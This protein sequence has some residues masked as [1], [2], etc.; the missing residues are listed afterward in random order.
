MSRNNEVT[1]RWSRS[2]MLSFINGAGLS[3]LG[4]QLSNP[5]PMLYIIL[6][7]F[8]MSLCTFW[9]ILNWKTQLWIDYWQS[10]LASMEPPPTEL[11]VFRVFTGKEWEKVNKWPTFHWLLNFLP[12]TFFVLWLTIIVTFSFIEKKEP[13]K[14]TPTTIF[15]QFNT[16]KGGV[17]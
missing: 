3:L 5:V 17:K 6:G 13:P 10:C 15:F 14:T 7:I 11:F 16:N 1:L 12:N 8:G 9:R 2:V 4:A